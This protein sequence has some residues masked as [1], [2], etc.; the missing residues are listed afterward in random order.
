[1]NQIVNS[2]TVI[3]TAVVGIALL[4]VILSR[5]SQTAGV[6]NAGANGFGTILKAAEAPVMGSSIG[7]SMGVNYAGLDTAGLGAYA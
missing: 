3:L 2:I 7:G 6:F 4:S 1:M 5:N